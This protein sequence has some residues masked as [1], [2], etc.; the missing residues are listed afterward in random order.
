MLYILRIAQS[1][2]TH[3]YKVSFEFG[4]TIQFQFMVKATRARHIQGITVDAGKGGRE[5]H[6]FSDYRGPRGGGTQRDEWQGQQNKGFQE[7]HAAVFS[8]RAYGPRGNHLQ[9]Q[10]VNF[11]MF[12]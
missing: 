9:Q 3:K 8:R 12:P 1:N 4:Y 11:Q 10:G 2:I 7:A 5:I 6:T